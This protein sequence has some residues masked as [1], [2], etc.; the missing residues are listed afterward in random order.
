MRPPPRPA[1]APTQGVAGPFAQPP[2]IATVLAREFRAAELHVV[3]VRSKAAWRE[4]TKPRAPVKP[5][6]PA[7]R[8]VN[9][10]SSSG[11]A[12]KGGEP[13]ATTKPPPSGAKSTGTPREPS[14]SVPK[15]SSESGTISLRCDIQVRCTRHSDQEVAHTTRAEGIT[16]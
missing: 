9:L 15:V 11:T 10:A 14:E 1:G 12:R 16:S 2:P 3:A 4:L 6:P 5:P 8:V 7:E 13:S